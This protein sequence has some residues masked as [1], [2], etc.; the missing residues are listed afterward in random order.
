MVFLKERKNIIEEE[1][2]GLWSVEN[3]KHNRTGSLKDS[4][5]GNSKKLFQSTLVET[6]K[7]QLEKIRLKQVII[8]LISLK[9][10]DCDFVKV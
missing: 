1:K 3:S 7:K 9:I 5:S 8:P 4:G 2:Q 6:E 10:I